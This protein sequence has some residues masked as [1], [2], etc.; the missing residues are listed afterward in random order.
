MNNIKMKAAPS[1]RNPKCAP[2][3]VKL[4]KALFGILDPTNPLHVVVKATTTT[5]FFSAA[6]SGEFLKKTLTSFRPELH[7]KPSNL[8]K[9][10]DW[11]GRRVTVAHPPAAPKFIYNIWAV[12]QAAS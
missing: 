2:W 3:T 8:S 10:T 9:K 7:V 6:H 11:G 4:L 5:I 12:A 1:S